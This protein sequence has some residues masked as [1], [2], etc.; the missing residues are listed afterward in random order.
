[1][2]PKWTGA[3]ACLTLAAA[4]AGCGG[5]D[6]ENTTGDVQPTREPVR[7]DPLTRDAF[8]VPDNPLEGISGTPKRGDFVGYKP[9]VEN[10]GDTEK[11]E[12]RVKVF[13]DG[14]KVKDGQYTNFYAS[15]QK[16]SEGQYQDDRLTGEW[17]WW[18]EDG[19]IAKKVVYENGRPAKE[20]LYRDDGTKERERHYTDGKLTKE[21]PFDERGNPGNP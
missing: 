5:G 12:Y 10:F 13:A 20:T 9:V 19:T 8:K 4:L 14:S 21:V 3:L 11:A 16:L 6:D 15:G 1:M 7:Q 2:K 18:Y 17:T